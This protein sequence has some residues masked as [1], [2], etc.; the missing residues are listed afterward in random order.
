MEA[1]PHHFRVTT[2]K[3]TASPPTSSD[4]DIGTGPPRTHTRPV[5]WDVGEA[6]R[7]HAFRQ[8]L[9]TAGS[10]ALASAVLAAV[11][12]SFADGALAIFG[13]NAVALDQARSAPLISV[14]LLP[15]SALTSVLFGALR[16][17]GD[18]LWPMAYS[19]AASL[20][21]L[22]PA[23]HLLIGVAGLGLA[24][25]FW[26]LTLAEATRGG[27]LLARWLRRRRQAVPVVEDAAPA[28]DDDRS[29]S[30]AGLH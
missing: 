23:S 25:A 15:L 10:T 17:A 16:S 7:Q 18:V 22:V 26:A 6:D 13:V 3:R 4:L 20:L 30:P 19:V 12:W 24:G 27:L 29:A 1:N 28:P 5:G 14:A 9:R 8:T 2:R 21:A 11:L